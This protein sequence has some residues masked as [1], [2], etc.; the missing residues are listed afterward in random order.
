MRWTPLVG[1][2]I[3]V[4]AACGTAEPPAASEPEPTT[5]SEVQPVTTEASYGPELAAVVAQ[6]RTDLADRLEVEESAIVVVSAEAVTWADGSLG[7]PQPGMMYTQALVEGARVVLQ[8]G[9]RFYDY[10]AG[11]G[12][13]P[14]LCESEADD[15]GHDEVPP[16]EG[17]A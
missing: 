9:G 6:A 17:T 1:A 2:V 8:V 4:A 12:V 3:L 10:H 13:G 14:F 15:G 16:L 5:T 11:G 7:C